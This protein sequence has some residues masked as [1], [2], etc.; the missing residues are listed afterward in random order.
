M[1][2]RYPFPPQF[3]LNNWARWLHHGDAGAPRSG[4]CIIGYLMSTVPR[5]DDDDRPPRYIPPPI[6]SEAAK[7]VDS[8]VRGM[9]HAD[10]QVAKWAWVRTWK[11]YAEVRKD[12]GLPKHFYEKR[13]AAIIEAVQTRLCAI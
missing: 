11:R 10:N 2:R 6:N 13:V 9:S 7:A 3:M 1:D 12:T 4:G 8:V 5:E